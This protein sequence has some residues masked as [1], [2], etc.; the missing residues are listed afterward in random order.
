MRREGHDHTRSDNNDDE[1]T[2]L[3][4]ERQR[5]RIEKTLNDLIMIDIP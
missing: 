4:G 5:I 2:D 3:E 1:E